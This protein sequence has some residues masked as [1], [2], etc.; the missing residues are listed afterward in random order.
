[1]EQRLIDAN[2]LEKKILKR[3]AYKICT[4][5]VVAMIA[6]APTVDAVPAVHGEWIFDGKFMELHKFHCSKCMR[7]EFRMSAYC[8]NCGARMKGEQE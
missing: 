6:D 5:D 1:M 7:T 3:G 4:D 8:P 2:A